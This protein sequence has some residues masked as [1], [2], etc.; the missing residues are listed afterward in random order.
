MTATDTSIDQPKDNLFGVCN[1]LGED[2]GFNPLWLRL[3]LAVAFLAAPVAV[4]IGYFA[5][6]GA[7][8][9][10]RFLFPDPNR[11]P[12]P[13]SRPWI[14]PQDSNPAASAANEAEEVVFAKAA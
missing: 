4:T 7:V 1:A 2:F 11:A 12:R 14:V 3:A 5:V 13:A 8:L 9:A 10:S 6:G